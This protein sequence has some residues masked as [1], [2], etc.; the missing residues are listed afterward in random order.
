[1]ATARARVRIEVTG[2]KELQKALRGIR[3]AQARTSSDAQRHERQQTRTVERE[4][5][6]QERAKRRAADRADQAN[7]R[8]HQARRRWE[9][10]TTREV[11][12]QAR[13]QERASRRRTGGVGA[14]I[15]RTIVGAGA[16]AEA[17]VGRV[18]GMQGALGI[19]SQEQRIQGFMQAQQSFIRLAA[20]G[21]LTRERRDELWNRI[22]ETA[23]TTN[24]DPGSL[25]GALEVA[26]NRFSDLEGFAQN[27]QRIAEVSQ[28]TGAP[29][30]DWVGAL[31]EFQRQMNVATEDVPDLIGMVT[32]AARD[33]SIEA[34]DIAANFAG[35]MS[36]FATLRGG[37]GG[38][39]QAR[40]FM[41]LSEVMGAGGRSSE[42]TR[43]LV[44]NLMSILSRSEVQTGIERATGNRNLFDERGVMQA[45]FPELFAAMNEAR[46]DAFRSPRALERM[47]IKDVQARDAIM[48]VLAQ[49]ERG[50]GANPIAD[51][52]AAS[53]AEGNAVI[54]QTMADLMSSASGRAMAIDV[55]A[56]VETMAN[57]ERV[58]SAMTRLVGPMVELEAEYPLLTQA[59]GTLKDVVTSTGIAMAGMNF[60][61]LGGGAAAQAAAAAPGLGAGTTAAS[62]GAAPL[63]AAVGGGALAIAAAAELS[64]GLSNAASPDEIRRIREEQGSEAAMGRVRNDFGF[65]QRGALGAGLSAFAPGAARAIE[66]ALAPDSRQALA[67]DVARASGEQSAR[68]P[69]GPARRGGG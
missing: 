37:K 50:S 62:I 31:G 9:R 3:Q 57:G 46:G 21:G 7:E 45:S 14:A 67:A 41:G 49:F 54:D 27:I 15:G 66:V 17:V 60:L 69:G 47:K 2:D 28:A 4:A 12:R 24:V 10:E 30:E 18:Q 61:G 6:E 32:Q 36:S 55:G 42:E 8:S 51:I 53:S 40:E 59:M 23:R 20:Q 38:L 52:A 63:A 58:V 16:A 25:I 43:T 68:T 22:G 13:A 11:E 19:Q 5:R 35:I 29:L 56:Q 39:T 33:G 64:N 48:A 26:Q 34:G 65:M 1:M 44:T